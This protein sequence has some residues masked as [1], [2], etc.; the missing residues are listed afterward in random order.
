M[1]LASCRVALLLAVLPA[2]SSAQD[3]SS[4]GAARLFGAASLPLIAREL[5]SHGMPEAALDEALQAMRDRGHTASEASDVLR[6]AMP[7]AMSGRADSAFGQFVR[8][9]V[10]Q[11]LRGRTLAQAV[12]AEIAKRKAAAPKRPPGRQRSAKEKV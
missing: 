4:S 8:G 7:E 3:Q 1:R 12:Q 9:Q 6:E 5:R 2:A 11:G 10:E